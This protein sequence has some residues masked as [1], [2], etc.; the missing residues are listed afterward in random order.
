MHAMQTC[1]LG[2]LYD[3]DITS[4]R[5]S[6]YAVH[7]SVQ[8]LL[9]SLRIRSLLA[10]ASVLGTPAATNHEQHSPATARPAPSSHVADCKAA[11]TKD[12]RTPGFLCRGVALSTSCK[13]PLPAPAPAAAA[14]EGADPAR[15]SGNAVPAAVTTTAESPPPPL[16]A[17]CGADTSL[18][19]ISSGCIIDADAFVDDRLLRLG[20][21][22]AACRWPAAPSIA[23]AAAKLAGADG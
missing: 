20:I 1:V 14:A 13:P 22:L 11:C 4:V 7:H 6:S 18:S 8:R 10:S 5:G 15:N 9:Q 3:H 2:M 23:A 21:R 12:D 19:C 17:V 16:A